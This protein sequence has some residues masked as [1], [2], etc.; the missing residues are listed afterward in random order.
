MENL[1][2][3]ELHLAPQPEVL[4]PASIRFTSAC[5]QLQ[6]ALTGCVDLAGDCCQA[7]DAWISHILPRPSRT[8]L[9]TEAYA[10]RFGQALAAV[11]VAVHVLGAV[12]LH[13]GRQ[14]HAEVSEMIAGYKGLA[15]TLDEGQ[16]AFRPDAA[17]AAMLAQGKVRLWLYCIKLH[18][19]YHS[20][21]IQ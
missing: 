8:G 14:K 6:A 16:G 12:K 1:K 4:Q 9:T 21:L 13:P 10:A 19:C 5:Q 3:L 11:A 18:Y 17:M 2:S 20:V 7:P 15:R